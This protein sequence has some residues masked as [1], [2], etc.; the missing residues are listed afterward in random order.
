M[1]ADFMV[2]PVRFLNSVFL[3][4]MM[5]ACRLAPAEL[6][7]NRTDDRLKVV[8]DVVFA[9]ELPFTGKL[10][11]LYPGLGD[12]AEIAFYRHGIEH[13]VLMRFYPGGVVKDQR[14]FENGRKVGTFTSWWV[15]GKKKLEY[16]FEND[17]Y[18][19]RCREWNA[20]GLLIKE[21]NYERGHEQGPQKMFYD[22]GKIRANYVVINGRRYGL[23]GTKNC[24][25]TSDS[26]FKN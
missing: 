18:Q 20:E 14:A 13:G 22:N 8:G 21:M 4:G 12:T 25:N 11:T 24:V 16:L 5:M 23:L 3:I 9:N 26:V 7:M 2:H 17:E 6:V 1:A 19:G 15:N 10:Y